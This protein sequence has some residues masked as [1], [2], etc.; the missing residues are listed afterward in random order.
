[1]KTKLDA[2]TLAYIEAA[3]WSST[4]GRDISDLAPKTLEA[5]RADCEV[6]QRDNSDLFV[7]ICERYPAIA[8]NDR[9]AGR[10]FWLTRNGHGCGFWDRG[11]SAEVDKA[12]T[13][14]AHAYGE[15]NWYVGNDGLV[16]Q[17]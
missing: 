5:M 8:L 10:D 12:L 6:F 1:M 14:G 9:S 13:D 4:D 17:M 2:F 3:L 16:Y 15:S 11:Y 7:E